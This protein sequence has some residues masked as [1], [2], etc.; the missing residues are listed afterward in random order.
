MQKNHSRLSSFGLLLGAS[1]LW[2]STPVAYAQNLT[3]TSR[4]QLWLKADAGVTDDG[5]GNVLSWADQSPSPDKANQTAGAPD[6]ANAPKRITNALSG[7]PVLRFDGVDDYLSIQD[8]DS[9]S[10]TG[11]LTTFFVIK[12]DDFAGF[13]AVW[14]KTN[15]NFPAATDWYTLPNSGVPRLYRGAGTG[16]GL[17]TTDSSVPLVAGS[18]LTVGFAMEGN[19]ASHF[20]NTTITGT[21]TI[22]VEEADSD[23]PLLIGSRADLFTKMKGD[24][25]EILIYDR[26]LTATERETVVTY[27]GQKYGIANL[28]PTSSLA[29]TPAGPSHPAGTTL[30]LTATAADPDGS[31]S[32]VKFFANGT[33]LGTATAPPYKIRVK[34][35]TPGNFSFTATAED[36]KL[37]TRESTAVTRTVAAGA[38]PVLGVTSN[39]QLW[40]KADKGVKKGPGDSIISWD[41]QSGKA[42]HATAV[43]EG[44]APILAAT[45]INGLPALRFDGTDDALQVADSDSISI[46]GD[47][48]SFFVTKMDDFVTFRAVWGKTEGNKPT[49]QRCCL[50]IASRRARR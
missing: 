17:G 42:N 39:L 29:V 38:A 31:I 34:L 47:I 4:L 19:T 11:D 21:G 32:N 6:A 22:N 44:T 9:L 37:A 26:A 12:F 16:T 27:L 40:L 8:T 25:A 5:A 2:F 24:I 23:T 7:K 20:L 15:N 13:R 18:F 33:L 14:A 46:I 1:A 30:T 48:T 50:A 41:D 45:A 36:N 43:D 35:D 10:I 3:V 28:S 49:G